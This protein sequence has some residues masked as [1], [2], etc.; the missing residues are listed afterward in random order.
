MKG[1]AYINASGDTVSDNDSFGSPDYME[2][3]SD[4]VK[5]LIAAISDDDYSTDN[6]TKTLNGDT[7][8]DGKSAM[9]LLTYMVKNQYPI[10]KVKGMLDNSPDFGTYMPNIENFK[11]LKFTSDLSV[12]EVGGKLFSVTA[13]TDN[14]SWAYAQNALK[15]DNMTTDGGTGLLAGLDQLMLL[16][17]KQFDV[18]EVIGTVTLQD[19]NII[20]HVG[21]YDGTDRS[22]DLSVT[23]L[24]E[25]ASTGELS[26]SGISESKG[27]WSS[28]NK[29]LSYTFNNVPKEKAYVIR[30]KMDGYTNDLPDHFFYADGYSATMEVCGPANQGYVV[31]PKTSIDM[32]AIPGIGL[33]AGKDQMTLKGLILVT[34]LKWVSPLSYSRSSSTDGSRDLILTKD[35]STLKLEALAD[36]ASMAFITNTSGTLGVST[37][38]DDSNI[39][40]GGLGFLLGQS[41]LR[42]ITG[43]SGLA[44]LSSPNTS[45]TM[46]PNNY[47]DLEGRALVLKIVQ[48]NTGL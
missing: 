26:A 37:D 46:C 12:S 17:F 27:N 6:L 24:K 33:F 15:D 44:G 40:K 38:C 18:S 42:D 7:E 47:G 1:G 19:P 35:G 3:R 2:A 48:V 29:T 20:C 21:F 8:L 11:E 39:H 31:G 36:S 30:F 9:F 10:D 34:F 14:A 22:S 23:L 28:D 5:G 45:L 43:S 41:N 16:E 4:V 13:P 25:D 32:Q